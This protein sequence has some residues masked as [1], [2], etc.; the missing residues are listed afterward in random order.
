MRTNDEIHHAIATIKS[1]CIID[2]AQWQTK[3]VVSSTLC[4]QRNQIEK[5]MH[6][7]TMSD[8]LT[9]MVK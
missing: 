3:R 9:S 5:K 2:K 8:I 1:K 4:F 7:S 6:I